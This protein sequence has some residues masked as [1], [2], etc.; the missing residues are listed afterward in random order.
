GLDAEVVVLQVDVEIG[1]DETLADHLPDDARHFIAVELDD[2]TGD[3][4]LLHCAGP[5][6]FGKGRPAHS[7]QTCRAKEAGVL[8]QCGPPVMRSRA[9][10]NGPFYQGVTGACGGRAGAGAGPP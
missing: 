7:S 1:E 8:A 5:L 2:R 3:L 6:T 10:G 4:D 9:A